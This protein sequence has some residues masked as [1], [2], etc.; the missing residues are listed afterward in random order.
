MFKCDLCG[1]DNFKSPQGLNGHKRS[2]GAQFNNVGSNG[3]GPD[4]FGP[5]STVDSSQDTLAGVE[6]LHGEF[7]EAL[8]TIQ[9][10]IDRNT[11]ALEKLTT[12]MGQDAGSHEKGFCEDPDCCGRIKA[13]FVLDA[14]QQSRDGIFNI[15]GQA[16]REEDLMDE[17]D[18]LAIRF[19]ALEKGEHPNPV[20]NID[21]HSVSYQRQETATPPISRGAPDTFRTEDLVSRVYR[22]I[23][24]A[25][26]IPLA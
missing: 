23:A 9:S 4:F 14:V 7:T 20:W 16:A 3:F 6:S 17:A 15:L 1:R 8:R 10:S 21:G 19:R 25:T 22:E 13:E 24:Q 26:P 2:C 12:Q 5:T 11:Q 18:R